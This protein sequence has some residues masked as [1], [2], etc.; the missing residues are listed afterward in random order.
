[1]HRA[2]S[3]NPFILEDSFQVEKKQQK[4]QGDCLNPL[5]W[6]KFFRS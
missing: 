6:K 5:F 3:H 2:A 1:M 4:G